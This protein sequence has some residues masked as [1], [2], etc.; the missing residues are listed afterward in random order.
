MSGVRVI[1]LNNIEDI[2]FNDENKVFVSDY[3]ASELSACNAFPGDIIFAKMMPAGR[4]CILPDTYKRY[5]LGSDAIRCKLDKHKVDTIFFLE[6]VNRKSFRNLVDSKTAGSTRKRIG[7]PELKNIP[8]LIPEKKEQ[9]KIG[10]LFKLLEEKNN[11]L[12][13][14]MSILKKYKE[15][16]LNNHFFTFKKLDFKIKNFVKIVDGFSFSTGDYSLYGKFKIISIA[17]ITGGRYMENLEEAKSICNIPRKLN[18]DQ[19]IKNGDLLITMTGNVG[20]TSF[21]NSNDCLLNQRVCKLLTSNSFHKELIYQLTKT[22]RF[23]KTM[24]IESAGAAQ[25]NISKAAIYNFKFDSTSANK[26][27][28]QVLKMIDFK[29]EALKLLESKL[30]KLKQYLLTNLFI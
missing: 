3:K 22:S 14:K 27:N 6:A 16:L 24:Q 20:R 29:I 19:T 23:K 15:G 30:K 2:Y 11:L 21:S 18:Y 8:L 4:A 13:F 1:Q 25:K 12:N 5:L 9:E 10:N 17:N 7:L 28:I 26:R